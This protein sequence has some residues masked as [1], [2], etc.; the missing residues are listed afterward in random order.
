MALPIHLVWEAV[1]SEF[2]LSPIRKTQKSP[3]MIG[4]TRK[5]IGSVELVSSLLAR[6]SANVKGLIFLG[7]KK[8]LK[9]NV[10]EFR[11]A[12]TNATM[13]ANATSGLGNSEEARRVAP[14]SVL[15]PSIAAS[16]NPASFDW[17]VPNIVLVS[18]SGALC[19]IG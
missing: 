4:A 7:N 9:L 3:L 8:E 14:S 18:F 6:C 19:D 11:Y 10:E 5:L 16:D 2:T 13:P 12:E 15:D 1:A 17:K